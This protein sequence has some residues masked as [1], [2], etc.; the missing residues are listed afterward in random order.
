MSVTSPLIRYSK[1][2]SF[3]A[4]TATSSLPW[5]VNEDDSWVVDSSALELF[6]EGEGRPHPV[7]GSQAAPG[8]GLRVLPSRARLRSYRPG[9]S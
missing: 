8:R 1:A 3:I 5:L 6:D 7:A 2:P 9:E 4:E